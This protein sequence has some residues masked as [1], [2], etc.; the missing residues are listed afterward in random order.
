MDNV[1]YTYDEIR[2]MHLELTNG[3][4]SKCPMCP[5]YIT[6]GGKINPLLKLDEVSLDQF[7]DWFDVEFVK[8]LHWV[9]SCGN[10][11]DPIVAK[12]MLEIYDYMRS[13]NQQMGLR[14]HTNASARST[15]WWK[16]LGK[17]CNLSERGD[18]ITFSI[19]GLEDTN[20]LYRRGTVFSKILENVKAFISAGGIAHWDYIVFRHNEHQVDTAFK[21]AKKLGFKNFNI[22]RTSRWNWFDENGL[23]MYDVKDKKGNIIYT[24]RQPLNEK[25][26][27]DAFKIFKN[28]LDNGPTN[29]TEGE[30]FIIRDIL[31]QWDPETK[32]DIKIKHNTIPIKCRAQHV[33]KKYGGNGGGNE[34]FLTANGYIYPCCFLGGI[35]D[36]HF[37]NVEVNEKDAMLLLLE[38]NGGLDSI[39]L[40]KHNLR[41]ILESDLYNKMIVETFELGHP[42]RSFQCSSC[43]GESN[44]L[45]SGE[46]GDKHKGYINE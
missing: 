6:N 25:Y 22:K 7:K 28:N 44:K 11:G 3:C 14:V 16:E 18:Y 45:D 23:G 21:I 5:R 38:N 26:R 42:H 20:H 15:D 8:K 41:K 46:L 29:L 12:D 34:I 43:C 2:C 9:M 1:L 39:S 4:N 17:M 36:S 13:N 35:H 10:Y 24:Y 19:D 31:E 37:G 33:D 27:E 30:R 32:T 40:K